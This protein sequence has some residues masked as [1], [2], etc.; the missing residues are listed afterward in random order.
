MRQRLKKQLRQLAKTIILTTCFAIL[1]ITTEQTDPK[2]TGNGIL[3]KLYSIYN[4]T[5]SLHEYINWGSVTENSSQT[6]SEYICETQKAFPTKQIPLMTLFTTM[7]NKSSKTLINSITIRNWAQF[8]PIVK[9]VLFL[10][11]EQNNSALA[12]DARKHSWDVLLVMQTNKYGTPVFKDMFTRVREKYSTVFHGYSNGDILYDYT[13]PKTLQAVA[14][15]LPKL[16]ST[17]LVGMRKNLNMTKYLNYKYGLSNITLKINVDDVVKRYGNQ[18]ITH[19]WCQ[20]EV[21]KL[22]QGRAVPFSP[23]AMDYFFLSNHLFP[24][25]EVKDVV[26]GRPGYDNYFHIFAKDHKTSA[27]DASR[28]INAVHQTGEKTVILQGQRIRTTLDTTNI[29]W[30]E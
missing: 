1:Y 8:G 16:N 25:H 12:S 23:Q 17:L 6:T 26:I 14:D 11:A 2:A 7:V 5:L 28:S 27:I 10:S 19:P 29:W 21:F 24:W 13:L 3:W 15:I 18:N 22:A 9:P 20:Q 4:Q 30:E